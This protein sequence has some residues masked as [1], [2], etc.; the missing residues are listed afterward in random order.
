M[1]PDYW[2]TKFKEEG[3][4]WKFEPSDSVLIAAELFKTNQLSKILI[5]GVGYGRNAK[6]FY[7]KRFQVTGIEISQTAINLAKENG[8]NFNIHHGSVTSMPFDNEQYDGIFC[9]AMIHL[10][11]RSE[12]KTFL[13]ACYHQLRQGGL[14]VFTVA[15]TDANMYGNGKKLSRD[16]FEIQKGLNVYFYSSESVIKEFTGFGLIEVRAIDE[17]IKH[18]E[19][20][21]PLRCKLVICKKK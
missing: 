2:E 4:A 11:N 19:G 17:P 20:Y 9:Y 10:L 8:L 6:V 14:M 15:S 3:I 13:K 1:Q 5:P 21:E 7:D 12:R 18:M 16:R